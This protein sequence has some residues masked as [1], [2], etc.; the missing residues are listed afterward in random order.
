[1]CVYFKQSMNSKQVRHSKSINSGFSYKC[2]NNDENGKPFRIFYFIPFHVTYTTAAL[3]IHFNT[4]MHCNFKTVHCSVQE[5]IKYCSI[6]F[7]LFVSV[8]SK[9]LDLSFELLLFLTKT[10]CQHLSR[11]VYVLPD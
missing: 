11:K 5:V 7:Q 6:P 10:Q 8:L 4:F 3:S 1:V 9:S 2:Q